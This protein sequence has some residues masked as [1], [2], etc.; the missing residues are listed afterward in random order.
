MLLTN[1]YLNFEIVYQTKK[2]KR[3]DS[4]DSLTSLPSTIIQKHSRKKKQ[5]NSINDHDLWAD[6]I[7]KDLYTSITKMERKRQ[8]NIYELIYTEED[9]VNSL[10][11]L[12][13][14]KY[15][16]YMGFYNKRCE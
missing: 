15:T 13:T 3:H 7:S 12:Q 14:V 2:F 8:E 5:E 16:L 10:E 6:N 11:Y 4:S 1:N 9:Y